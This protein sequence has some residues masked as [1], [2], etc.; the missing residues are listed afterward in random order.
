[1]SEIFNKNHNHFDDQDDKL[2]QENKSN[3]F[4]KILDLYKSN[5]CPNTIFYYIFAIISFAII[6]ISLFLLYNPKTDVEF[7]GLPFGGTGFGIALMMII[8]IAKST[9]ICILSLFIFIFLIVK[10]KF[11]PAFFLVP[12][13]IIFLLVNSAILSIYRDYYIIS[14]D[15]NLKSILFFIQFNY[16]F[17]PFAY[18]PFAILYTIITV[19]IYIKH[20]IPIK[21]TDL[22]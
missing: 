19:I 2:Q 3:T 10:K 12:F 1:M 11:Q 16:L 8:V 22:K 18:I 14:G 15:F 13:I 20:I 6:P 4:I 9:V 17:L 21:R 7:I 5:V